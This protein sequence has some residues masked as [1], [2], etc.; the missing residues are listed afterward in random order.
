MPNDHIDIIVE[1]R[2]SAVIRA[3][4]LLKERQGTSLGEISREKVGAVAAAL[5]ARQRTDDNSDWCFVCDERGQLLCCD[6]CP[7][8]MH[9]GCV[10][11]KAFPKRGWNCPYC[12]I[13]AQNN[14]DGSKVGRP[15]AEVRT[16][17]YS[18]AIMEAAIA[19]SLEKRKPSAIAEAEAEA[20]VSA[21]VSSNGLQIVHTG[22]RYTLFDSNLKSELERFENIEDALKELVHVERY[23]QHR[24]ANNVGLT[25]RKKEKE[26]EKGNGRGRG[27]EKSKNKNDSY[28]EEEK[29]DED[30]EG[31]LNT[32]GEMWCYSCLD[33]NKIIMC[34]FCGCRKCFG[35]YDKE[36]LLLCDDCDV[37]YHTYCLDPPLKK[38]PKEDENWFC[39]ACTVERAEDEK[40][41]HKNREEAGNLVMKI[42]EGAEKDSELL[43][44]GRKRG[45]KAKIIKSKSTVCPTPTPCDDTVKASDPAAAQSYPIISCPRGIDT[46]TGSRTSVLRNRSG[47]IKRPLEIP[48]QGSLSS[49]RPIAAVSSPTGFATYNDGCSVDLRCVEQIADALKAGMDSG[50]PTLLGARDRALLALFREWAPVNDLHRAKEL[51]LEQKRRLMNHLHSIAPGMLAG[52]ESE[53]L[54]PDQL[55]Q[56]RRSLQSVLPPMQETTQHSTTTTPSGISASVK[57]QSGQ[58]MM[59]T[60]TT[61]PVSSSTPGKANMTGSKI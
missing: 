4:D 3:I 31:A 47:G 14:G 44:K 1:K 58:L 59:P 41:R 30:E 36:N 50:E 27:G 20:E 9:L 19:E 45:R 55:A 57:Q 24:R 49:A 15:S 61:T 5:R 40:R 46:N 43:K 26:K 52:R 28:E 8:A 35:K 23:R 34:A 39:A 54:K 16:A 13:A 29:E 60:S 6:T 7:R 32:D 38:M 42:E 21:S 48:A 37:E 51:L 10:K 53:F 12:I 56:Y 17:Q 33:D 25:S 11:M 22:R 18:I 2:H